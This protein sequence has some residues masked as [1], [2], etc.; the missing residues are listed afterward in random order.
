MYSNKYN[1]HDYYTKI[2]RLIFEKLEKWNNNKYN[3]DKEN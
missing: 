3:L 1:T 2:I